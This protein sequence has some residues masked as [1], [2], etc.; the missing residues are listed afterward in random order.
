M[1]KIESLNQ[2]KS[3]K[4]G[5]AILVIMYAIMGLG[6]RSALSTWFVFL[7]P[8]MLFITAG[9]IWVDSKTNN[10]LGWPVAIIVIL[11]GYLIEII[12]V[13]FPEIFGSYKYGEMMG[14]KFFEAPP[15]IG[16]E[17]LIIVWGSFAMAT[18]FQVHP[19]LKWL[20]AA[21]I[22]TGLFWAIEPVARHYSLWTWYEATIPFRNYGLRFILLFIF[23][24]LFEKYPLMAKPRL[25]QTAIIC[26]ILFFIWLR[27][28]IR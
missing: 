20:F 8:I 13:H 12:G 19:V 9:M 25:G 11:A 10:K 17:W 4:A 6:Y 16:V 2:F 26:Q 28:Q 24:A 27:S 7:T 23:A 15:I 14:W 5:I 1:R 18:P 3:K 21:L 22:G